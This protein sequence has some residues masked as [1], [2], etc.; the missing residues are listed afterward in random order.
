RRAPATGPDRSGSPPV[1]GPGWRP[2]PQRHRPRAG[3]GPAHAG[4]PRRSHPAESP[5]VRCPRCRPRGSPRPWRPA[6]RP[7][8]RAAGPARPRTRPRPPMPGP[9]KTGNRA[10]LL[11]LLDDTPG[12]AFALGVGVAVTAAET[13]PLQQPAALFLP[14]LGILDTVLTVGRGAVRT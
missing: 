2:R 1:P 5:P 10:S 13:E 7:A 9:R 3:P 4:R 11:H 12:L 8:S 6:Q 14:R